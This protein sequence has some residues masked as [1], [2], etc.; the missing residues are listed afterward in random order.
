MLLGVGGHLACE[1]VL[2]LSRDHGDA[3]EEE[4]QVQLALVARVVLE[5][6]DDGELVLVVALPQGR[7]EVATWS[8]V[9][10]VE[11]LS[12]EVEALSEEFEGAPFA[13]H[14]RQLGKE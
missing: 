12:V 2:Q 8:K 7:I 6:S 3:I 1:S 4:D 5:L 14:S 9:R 10:Q 13:H 11:V